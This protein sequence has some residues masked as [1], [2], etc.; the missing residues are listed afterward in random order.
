MLVTAGNLN[1][2]YRAIISSLGGTRDEAATFADMF[3]VADLRGMDWQGLR[4][5]H[6]HVVHPI[7][8]G[9]TRLGQEIVVQRDA[10]ASIL[11]EA[12][13]ELGQVTCKRAMELAVAKA[14]D[15]GSCVVG[16]RNCGDT[17]L[18]AAYT[19]LAAE[20]DCIG[21]IFNN[22]NAFIAP[23]GG[24]G[25]MHGIDPLSIAIPAGEEYPVVVDM[26]LTRAQDNFDRHEMQ[27]PP[28]PLP[29]LMQFETMR[30]YVLSVAIELIAGGL[31]DMPLG[32]D[33]T[34]R[35]EAAVVVIAIHIPHF[36]AM[37]EFRQRVDGY[38][39]QV[40]ATE[41][42]EGAAEVL[43]PGERGFKEQERRLEHGIQVDDQVWQHIS[44]LANELRI[45]LQAEFA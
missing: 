34:K 26:A 30:E 14:S 38:I 45:D 5:I 39:R 25:P 27:S 13:G 44:E 23:W 36:I 43:L 20:Q 42:A 9:I 2:L 18:L 15:S 11:L 3:E 4:S 16:I 12:N 29:P 6:R 28:F 8:V 1:K 17:G 19:I 35:W 40:K 24:A 31:T 7:Q 10:A 41:L 22:T 33:K 21:I 37:S 32:R